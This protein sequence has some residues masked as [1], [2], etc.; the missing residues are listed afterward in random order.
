MTAIIVGT[1]NKFDPLVDDEHRRFPVLTIE[2][3]R[4]VDLGWV[5]E[6]RQQLYAQAAYEYQ[7]IMPELIMDAQNRNGGVGLVGGKM[8][9]ALGMIFNEAEQVSV[10]IPD[11]YWG[12]MGERS[13]QHRETSPLEEFLREETREIRTG[14]NATR[15]RP[16]EVRWAEGRQ[17]QQQ[18]LQRGNEGLW[19]GQMGYHSRRQEAERLGPAPEPPNT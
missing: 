18:R 12:A 8:D 9:D 2:R 3:G 11:R 10:R 4:Y 16:T 15:D 17:V 7:Y 13:A 1:T 19:L 14:G 6:N 5:Q